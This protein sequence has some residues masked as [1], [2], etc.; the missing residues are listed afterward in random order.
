MASP[1]VSVIMPVYNS[2]EY[3]EEAVRSI[4]GQTLDDFEFIVIDDGSTDGSSQILDSHEDKRMRVIHQPKRGI[5]E[6]LNL[7]LELAQGRYVARMDSDDISLPKRLATQVAFME[8]HPEVGICGTSCVLFGDR[9]AVSTP[10]TRNDD[11]RSWLV[12]GP[13]FA[14]PTV[15]MRRSLIMR[16]GLF[17][18]PGFKQAEDYELWIRF[19]KHC[20]MANLPEPLLLYRVREEQATSKH[21]EE[22]RRWSNL[23]QA[24]AIRLLGIEPTDEELALHLSLTMPVRPSTVSHQP[25]RIDRAEAWL[26]RLLEAN[27]TSGACEERAFAGV[28][29]E[30][31]R[32]LFVR[33]M[34]LGLRL[35][36][37]FMRSEIALGQTAM[38]S[39]MYLLHA[40]CRRIGNRAAARKTF[41]QLLQEGG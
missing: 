20:G 4:L 37:K 17:Y 18:D 16:N 9:H 3:L 34:R 33:E 38:S 35:C 39:L 40:G 28:V 25:S 30:I 31:W 41:K 2:A 10:K 6:S 27:K 19:S 24:K 22:V 1:M 14:H 15:M 29:F 8:Q 11:I 36:R 5:V 7:G 13:C 21:G 23:V 26:V 32:S 12:F